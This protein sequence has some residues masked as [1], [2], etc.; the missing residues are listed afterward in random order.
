MSDRAAL[1]AAYQA[2]FVEAL[3]DKDPKDPGLKALRELLYEKFGP[4]RAPADARTYYVAAS[5]TQL[6][7]L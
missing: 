5:I 2:R 1:A 6:D 3:N 4:F 7:Q